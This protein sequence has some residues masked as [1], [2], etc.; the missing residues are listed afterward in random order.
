M[1]WLCTAVPQR[2]PY[3]DY[4]RR[5]IPDLR[6][7]YDRGAGPW[8]SWMHAWTTEPDEA[9]VIL[10]DD[11]CL[12]V[13]AAHTIERT[14]SEHPESVIQFF[15][16]YIEQPP[17]PGISVQRPKTWGGHLCYYLPP[18]LG[19][20]I[21]AAAVRWRMDRAWRGFD[22]DVVRRYLQIHKL[23]YLAVSPSVVQHQPGPS[24]LGLRPPDRLARRFDS[25]ELDGYPSP[26]SML[27]FIS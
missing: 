8:T 19:K 13:G 24:V 11:L 21:G 10:Q 9:R 14:I 2:E 1:I 23:T 17:E 26:N 4:L 16:R 3:V 20:H 22:D 5:H 25:P 27:R 18:G 15:D 12:R 7:I 6:T